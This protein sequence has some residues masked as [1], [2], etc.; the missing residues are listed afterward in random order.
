[1]PQPSIT[2][3]R[4]KIT[5]LKY[6][7]NFPGANELTHKQLETHECICIMHSTVATDVVGLNMHFIGPFPQ[8]NDTFM[9]KEKKITIWKK[10]PDV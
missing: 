6:H 2:K 9:T 5:Y 3:I 4:L 10:Y 1:M 7:S 8:E